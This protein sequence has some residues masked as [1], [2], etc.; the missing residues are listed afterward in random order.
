MQELLDLIRQYGA[1]IYALLFAYCAVKSGAL[2]LFAGY[3]AKAGALD[4]ISVFFAVLAGAYLGDE[5]RFALA[6]RYGAALIGRR[7]RLKHALEVAVRLL[8]RHGAFYILAYRYP[9]GLRTIGALPVG[10]TDMPWRRFT[11]LNLASASLWSVLL[12]GG[13]YLLGH[14]FAHGVMSWWGGLGVLLLVIFSGLTFLGWRQAA[15]ELI[16]EGTRP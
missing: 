3:A 13:G 8:N 4:P 12:V 15:R 9:K 11:L 7:R 16:P 5:A 2:P 14:V 6:R 1:L 10:L